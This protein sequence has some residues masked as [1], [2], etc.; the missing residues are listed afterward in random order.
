MLHTFHCFEIF[1]TMSMI[2]V[3]I[4]FSL[5][6]FQGYLYSDCLHTVYCHGCPL[7]SYCLPLLWP[8]VSL[9]YIYLL[10]CAV[11]SVWLRKRKLWVERKK[12]LTVCHLHTQLNPFGSKLTNAVLWDYWD[13]IREMFQ[14]MQMVYMHE[15]MFLKARV[16]SLYLLKKYVFREC[17]M[18]VKNVLEI[19][20]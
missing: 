20:T 7:M 3:H 1:W 9:C 4:E 5:F 18:E 16:L 15:F 12:G 13:I 14:A 6:F 19:L 17:C 8:F 11:G 10:F 2:L